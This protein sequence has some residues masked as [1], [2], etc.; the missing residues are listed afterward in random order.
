MNF[1]VTVGTTGFDRLFM[2]CDTL[3]WSGHV[4]RWQIGPGKFCP[5]GTGS[6]RYIA[7]IHEAYSW[8]DVVITHAGAG[9]VYTLL[10]LG[11][12]IIVV[13]NLTRRDKHQR[14]LARFVEMNQFGIVAWDPESV[15][16]A[17]RRLDEF[18]FKPYNK[19]GFFLGNEL[20]ARMKAALMGQAPAEPVRVKFVHRGS[21]Q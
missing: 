3:D 12:R 9:T 2:Y 7:N 5:A 17:I 6:E 18:D 13:P 4:V 8:A 11:K 19:Y 1:L 15:G 14:E 10:E 21:H 16:D 20:S